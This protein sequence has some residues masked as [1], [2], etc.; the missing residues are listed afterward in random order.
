M[1]HWQCNSKTTQEHSITDIVKHKISGMLPHFAD[2]NFL[3]YNLRKRKKYESK[4]KKQ[5][6]GTLIRKYRISDWCHQ[7]KEFFFPFFS[8][9]F[10]FSK[11]PLLTNPPP[12]TPPQPR[13]IHSP[14]SVFH[15]HLLF[16]GI[17]PPLKDSPIPSLFHFVLYYFFIRPTQ[18]SLLTSFPPTPRIFSS[19]FIS[20]KNLNQNCVFK[21]EFSLFIFPP[22]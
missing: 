22:F 8:I 3:P 12:P 6:E 7:I 19:Y 5:K 20:K 4:G 14:T 1:A 11:P 18:I 17:A 21:W 16:Q 9:F 10:P 15:H 2:Y 13:P